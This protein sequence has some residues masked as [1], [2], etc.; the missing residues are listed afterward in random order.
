MQVDEVQVPPSAA[1][2]R[3]VPLQDPI[4]HQSLSKEMQQAQVDLAVKELNLSICL[5]LV[6][7]LQSLD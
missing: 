2:D 5:V 6:S 3:T 7:I 1:L 4:Q